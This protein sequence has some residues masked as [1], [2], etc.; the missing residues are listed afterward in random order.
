MRTWSV[1][2]SSDPATIYTV[3]MINPAQWECTC[4][5]YT[6]AH[7]ECK[8]IKAIRKKYDQQSQ[9]NKPTRTESRPPTLPSDD[10]GPGQERD[11]L[12]GGELRGSGSEHGDPAGDQARAGQ[13]GDRGHR[14][15]SEDA[16]VGVGSPTTGTDVSGPT[17]GS[18]QTSAGED[19]GVPPRDEQAELRAK[20]LAQRKQYEEWELRE[21]P[22]SRA[23]HQRLA[24]LRKQYAAEKDKEKRRTIELMA[25]PIKI[26]I[27][28]ANRRLGQ[29]PPFD[30]TLLAIEPEET[31]AFEAE[32]IQALF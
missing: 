24:E 26:A 8:H 28:G 6:K 5:S 18:D 25:R 9:K 12:P 13:P 21:T 7:R 10:R 31:D 32:V 15:G 14:S 3:A 2:S 16:E 11:N 29:T 19:P 17:E 27:K 1:K 20:V 23:M 30:I 4:P 22:A